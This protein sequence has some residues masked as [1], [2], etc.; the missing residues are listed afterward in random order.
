MTR[1]LT[2]WC[3]T[4]P[5]SGEPTLEGR[6]GPHLDLAYSEGVELVPPSPF[7]GIC[8]RR[9]ENLLDQTRG[10]PRGQGQ[11]VESIARR[12]PANGI[13]HLPCLA[14]GCSHVFSNRSR[15]HDRPHPPTL[16]TARVW[17]ARYGLGRYVSGQT[18]PACGRPY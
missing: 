15:F 7:A 6:P 17:Y 9:F 5:R 4:S 16:V 8:D 18:L 3:G 10:L 14:R 2:N 1:T 11:D 13:G 12:P